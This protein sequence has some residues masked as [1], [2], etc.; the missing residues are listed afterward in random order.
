MGNP[1]TTDKYIDKYQPGQRVTCNGNPEGVIIG[2]YGACSYEVRLWR[3]NR[4]VGT[5]CVSKHDLDL[6]N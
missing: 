1:T 2:P 6:E 4:L 3:G 5:V